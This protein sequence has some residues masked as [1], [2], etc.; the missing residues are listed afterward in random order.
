MW[1]ERRY[2]RDIIRRGTYVEIGLDKR[3]LADRNIHCGILGWVSIGGPGI[4]K[5]GKIIEVTE[6]PARG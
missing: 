1:E 5:N 6:I 2:Y 4:A 3:I